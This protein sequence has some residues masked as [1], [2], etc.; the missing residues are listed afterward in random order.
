MDIE[1][2]NFLIFKS[3]Q[4]ASLYFR[5]FRCDTAHPPLFFVRSFRFLSH[6]QPLRRCSG[7]LESRL[8]VEAFV[9]TTA[10]RCA[11]TLGWQTVEIH[12]SFS[13]LCFCCFFLVSIDV[14][15]RPRVFG[16]W[17]PFFEKDFSKN[18]YAMKL[19]CRLEINASTGSFSAGFSLSYHRSAHK[20][21]FTYNFSVF[22]IDNFSVLRIE[23]SSLTSHVFPI[24]KRCWSPTTCVW[25]FTPTW[26]FS[27][28]LLCFLVREGCATSHGILNKNK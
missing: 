8:T 6:P 14:V 21:Q 18:N 20:L 3:H 26:H 5:P 17:I 23:N 2:I 24:W 16:C 1:N 13:P 9:F 15:D 27:T 7:G 22:R 28:G 11:R 10:A 25:C 12:H 4:R 19:E